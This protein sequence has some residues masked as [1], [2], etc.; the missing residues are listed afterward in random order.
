MYATLLVLGSE[1]GHPNALALLANF[2][3]GCGIAVSVTALVACVN[4]PYYIA[5]LQG[6]YVSRLMRTS[7]AAVRAKDQ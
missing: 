6:E 5:R 1:G 3:S 7:H 2:A 4:S